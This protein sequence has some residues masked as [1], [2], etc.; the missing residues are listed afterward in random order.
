M[1]VRD[2]KL[3]LLLSSLRRP[4]FFE[5]PISAQILQNWVC[6]EVGYST[7]SILDQLPTFFL[8]G[9]AG[10]IIDRVAEADALVCPTLR[11]QE[12]LWYVCESTVACVS[13]CW[14]DITREPV[15]FQ[16]V[17]ELSHYRCDNAPDHCIR[18]ERMCK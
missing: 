4:R 17:L 13:V 14:L 8:K 15:L 7:A 11:V 9:L 18:P 16:N 1:V 10:I 3:G 5:V 6:T 12:S 2:D